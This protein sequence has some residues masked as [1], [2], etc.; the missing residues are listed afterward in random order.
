MNRMHRMSEKKVWKTLMSIERRCNQEKRSVR[1]LIVIA[2]LVPIV[3]GGE[4][5]SSC[6][7][8]A[9]CPPCFRQQKR[10]RRIK[11]LSD[12]SIL[13]PAVSIDIKVFQTFGP[14]FRAAPILQI[15]T[16]L[17]ILLQTIDIKG[18]SDLCIVLLLRIYR[19]SGPLGPGVHPVH[20][21][22]P[23]NPGHPASDAQTQQ[24]HR[25]KSLEDLHVYRISAQYGNRDEDTCDSRRRGFKPRLREI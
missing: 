21:A 8:C 12:L 6:S 14:S 18:L 1:T 15:L 9:S 13:F 4:G 10:A 5:L 24:Q 25:R 22:N 16:I 3:F 11:V 19:H 2:T 20:P 17:A 23:D 7:S